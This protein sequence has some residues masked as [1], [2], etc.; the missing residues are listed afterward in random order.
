M[1]VRATFSGLDYSREHTRTSGWMVDLSA[2]NFV[3]QGTAIAAVTT[4]IQGVSLIDF[5]GAV[6]PAHV[7]TTETAPP[8]ATEAQREIKWRVSIRDAT[9][10]KLSSMEI[11]GADTSLL[12]ANTDLMDVSAG[13]GAALVTALEA[14]LVS[15]VGN[16]ITVEEVRLVGRRT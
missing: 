15:E 6:Y 12:V 8:A 9:T 7:T 10:N 1:T 16:A 11:G 14:E 3:A 5:D 13:A 4:A 2:G